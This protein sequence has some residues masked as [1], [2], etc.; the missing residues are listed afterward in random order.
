MTGI[1]PAI[2]FTM[3]DWKSGALP[4][5]DIRTTL[6]FVNLYLLWVISH[7]NL[8]H[9]LADFISKS[10]YSEVLFLYLRRIRDSNP[11]MDL[12]PPTCLANKPLYQ[13]E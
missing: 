1:E 13:F 5:G 9:N 2:C 7:M 6:Y 10:Q 8:M 12:T 11:C 3:P 4:L